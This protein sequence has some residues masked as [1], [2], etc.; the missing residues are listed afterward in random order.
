L[1]YIVPYVSRLDFCCSAR[2]H[3]LRATAPCI[4]LQ[5]NAFAGVDPSRAEK[6]NAETTINLCIRGTLACCCP[7]PG[8]GAGV[9][10]GFFVVNTTKKTDGTEVAHE[11]IVRL[12]LV[13]GGNWTTVDLMLFC[14]S[15]FNILKVPKKI[16]TFC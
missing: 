6:D 4:S 1:G 5:S 16:L 15:F 3:T 8:Y 9:Q 7:T 14:L 12:R 2:R 11:P 13:N 10:L